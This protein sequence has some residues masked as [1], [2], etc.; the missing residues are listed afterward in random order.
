MHGLICFFYARTSTIILYGKRELA[1]VVGTKPIAETAPPPLLSR[2]NSSCHL[3]RLL[4]VFSLYDARSGLLLLEA[5]GHFLYTYAVRVYTHGR[6]AFV[7]CLPVFARAS[8]TAWV[9]V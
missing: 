8:L 7:S 2:F 5:R 1:V 4:P 9:R 6:G 3:D